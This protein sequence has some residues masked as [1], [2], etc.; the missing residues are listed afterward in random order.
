MIIYESVAFLE[1]IAHDHGNAGIR[2]IGNF[3]V[4]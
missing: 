3:T 2:L 4:E 1:S